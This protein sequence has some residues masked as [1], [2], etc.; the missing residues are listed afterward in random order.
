MK[1]GEILVL[2]AYGLAGRTVID[3]LVKLTD[4]TVVAA[5]RDSQKLETVLSDVPKDRC[6]KLE[7][8]AGDPNALQKAIENINLVINTVGPYPI[9]GEQI[10]KAAIRNH[11][12]YIDCANEQIHFRKLQQ[13]DQSAKRNGIP[14]VTAAGAIPGLSTLLADKLLRQFPAAESVNITF[15]QFRHA[16][17][18]SGLGSIMSG[19]L[20]AV[21]LPSALIDGEH[22]P[23][24]LGRSFRKFDLP[25]PFGKRNML[26]VPTIDTLILSEKF[27]L[28]NLHTWFY[29]G[30]QPAWM[31]GLI[32]LLKPHKRQWAYE[33]IKKVAHHTD[34]AEFEKA[35]KA[36]HGPEAMLHVEISNATDSK[37]G[38][39]LLKDGAIPMAYLPVIIAKNYL[40]GRTAHTGLGTPLDFLDFDTFA[41]V[42][43]DA[44][45]ETNFHGVDG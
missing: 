4:K 45:I 31:F 35:I 37:S 14:I 32:R 10:A 38:T 12:A 18:G 33:L 9:F 26:E 8:D 40:T 36:G 6:R 11:T 43:Q 17:E 3:G 29:L 44:I 16:Y 21:N 15:A 25:A 41:D 39:V 42:A 34:S 27:R 28:Q 1:N 19:V 22:K 5:G 30:E 23:V 20:D 7:L 24:V 2:G 13:L